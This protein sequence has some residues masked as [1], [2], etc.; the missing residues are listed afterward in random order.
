[1]ALVEGESLM[2][3]CTRE[4]LTPLRTVFRW[5]KQRPE[6]REQYVLAR[7]VQADIMAEEIVAISDAAEDVQRAKLQIDARKWMAARLA[8]KTY[9]DRVTVAGDQASPLKL[10][11]TDGARERLAR[12]VAGQLAGGG[13]DEG[14]G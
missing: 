4:G 3:I 11:V 1:M 10:E 8:P 5:L 2:A 7:K 14:A 6:F 13:E 12:L 9:G